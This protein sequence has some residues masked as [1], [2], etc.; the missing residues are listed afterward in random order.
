MQCRVILRDFQ[1]IVSY[2]LL[3]PKLSTSFEG[4]QD[5]KELI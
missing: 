3:K 2:G 4:A 1:T 5:A